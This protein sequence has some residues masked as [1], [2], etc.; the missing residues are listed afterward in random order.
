MNAGSRNMRAVVLTLIAASLCAAILAQRYLAEK[1]HAAETARAA[2]AVTLAQAQRVQR[3][4]EEDQQLAV[5]AQPETDLV[6]ALETQL[7][8]VGARSAALA[9]V[10][11]RTG[12]IR[13][14]DDLVRQT[15]DV[16]LTA[17]D[18]RRTARFLAAWS[19]AEPLWVV[20]SVR[21]QHN[22]RAARDRNSGAEA[23]DV[24]L[25]LVSMHWDGAEGGG[26]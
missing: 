23:F 16:R 9:G 21:L 12:V 2:H 25:S 1:T 18:P 13:G 17:I 19:E 3:L 10:S 24:R 5:R 15:A 11:L 7:R 6:R 20:R 14:E 8:S 4:R 22:K 26:S